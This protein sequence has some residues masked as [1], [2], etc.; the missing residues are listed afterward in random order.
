MIFR[1]RSEIGTVRRLAVF[2]QVAAFDGEPEQ[3]VDELAVVGL[4]ATRNAETANVILDSNPR[5]AC[6]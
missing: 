3:G 6:R 4:G 2:G 1:T 5:P